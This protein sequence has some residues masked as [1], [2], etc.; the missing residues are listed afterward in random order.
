[1]I[2]S[3]RG[4]LLV[5]ACGA[6][7]PLDGHIAGGAADEAD[8]TTLTY[9]AAQIDGLDPARKAADRETME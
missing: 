4:V 9:F 7:D 8:A 6:F 5:L 3:A 2:E 1:M